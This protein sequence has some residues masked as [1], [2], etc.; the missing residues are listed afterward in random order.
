[1]LN[2]TGH[3]TP[4]DPLHKELAALGTAATLVITS[5]NAAAT[6]MGTN[7]LDLAIAAP[8]LETGLTQA[9]VEGVCRAVAA[10]DG[11]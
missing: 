6:V 2:A 3:L 9:V 5:D 7:L 11:A 4:A 1:M 8:A 10:G